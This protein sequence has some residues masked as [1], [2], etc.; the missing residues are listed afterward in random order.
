MAQDVRNKTDV[1]GFDPCGLNPD[2]YF[3]QLE[4]WLRID[5]APNVGFVTI[6]KLLKATSSTLAELL[7]LSVNQL[8]SLGINHQQAVA[9]STPNQ[10]ALAKVQDWLGS[11]MRHFLLHPQHPL[12][13][14]RLKQTARPPL[15]LFG[16]GNPALLSSHQM[17]IVG[18]RHPTVSGKQTAF[19][20]AGDLSR[21]GLVITS[22]MALGIDAQAHQGALE[23]GGRSIAVLGSGLDQLYPKRNTFIA[24][25]ILEQDGALVSEHMPDILPKAE[26]FPR[27]NRLVSGLSLGVIIVEAAIKSGSLITARYALEQN[28]E[29]FAVPGN[30]NNPMVCGCHY[31]IKQGAKLVEQIDDVIEEFPNIDFVNYGEVKKN[32]EKSA[33]ESLASDRLLDSVEYDATTLDVIIQRSRLPI[34]DVLAQLLE[35]ELRGLVTS[36]SGGYIKLRGK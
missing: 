7:N 13:P 24:D 11:D 12:F 1:D 35:Y 34:E 10:S 18:T 6:N 23:T 31:L 29:V 27:R 14:Q 21:R 17:A 3:T 33:S 25:K 15:L 22:G 8:L 36:V 20:L 4:H 5:L 32:F 16:K 28:R 30:I 2:L 9:L 19:K 26:N